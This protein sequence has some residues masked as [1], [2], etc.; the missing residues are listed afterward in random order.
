MSRPPASPVSSPSLF[1][2]LLA[3]SFP[4]AKYC[5]FLHQ[6][7]LTFKHLPSMFKPRAPVVQ[8]IDNAIWINLYRTDST[9]NANNNYILWITEHSDLSGG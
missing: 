7:L 1:S 4:I 9:V 3:T 2:R 8:K 5:A 6:R